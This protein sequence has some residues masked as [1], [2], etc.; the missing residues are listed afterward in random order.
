M[1]KS[2]FTILLLTAVLCAEAQYKVVG[3]L[4]AYSKPIGTYIN[5]VDYAK[6]TH[7]NIA[8]F[9]PDTT[10]VFPTAK[11]EGLPEIIAK[12][13]QYNVNVLLSLGGGAD[14]SQ[15]G[16]LLKDEN[17][18]AFID[19]VMALVEQYNADG[20][21]VDLEG[22]NIVKEYEKFVVELSARLKQKGKLITV[23]VAWGTREKFT[24]ACL[25][26]YDF[27]NLMTYGRSELINAS[28]DYPQMVLN[29]WKENRLVPAY[30]LA[31]G[32]SFYG[33]YDLPDKKFK[34]VNY[35][36][37]VAKYPEA[38][39]QDS[40]T[41]A[42]DG[43]L[44]RYNGIYK[45]KEKTKLAIKN[46]SGV[47]I[48]QLLQDTKGDASLLKAIDDQIHELKYNQLME[49]R[50]FF[51]AKGRLSLS[52]LAKAKGDAQ[53]EI[54]NSNG[55][56]VLVQ[57]LVAQKGYNQKMIETSQLPKDIYKVMLNID[58]KKFTITSYKN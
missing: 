48:W 43:R 2:L 15:Y 6:V 54:Y 29:Y 14:W 11:W 16:K 22:K 18:A 40:V 36:D 45:T 52:Y 47:M 44:I 25:E 46:A 33:R 17:R 9:N 1:K 10:G 32:I 31:V 58:K 23:A 50:G 4:P 7:L 30:K 56:K 28:L 57:K 51:G 37:L 49:V 34:T 38:A 27:I 55:Q 26:A 24:D 21:D 41:N 13:H 53:L 20:V 42:T 19:K 5:D 8:F 12:A 3:Y 39:K 35:G